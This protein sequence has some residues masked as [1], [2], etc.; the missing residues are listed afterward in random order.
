MVVKALKAIVQV[1]RRPAQEHSA[2]T[3]HADDDGPECCHTRPRTGSRRV[4]AL[5]NLRR[6]VRKPTVIP[7]NTIRPGTEGRELK[8][9]CGCGR[10]KDKWEA[11]D[12]EPWSLEAW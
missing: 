12:A 6:S 11:S 7:E 9:V 3:L 5:L 4:D 8:R 1:S 10:A 2:N